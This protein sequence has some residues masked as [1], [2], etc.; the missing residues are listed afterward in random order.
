MDPVFNRTAPNILALHKFCPH[1]VF[2]PGVQ[3]SF[4]ALDKFVSS[5]LLLWWIR[6]NLS[7]LRF[8]LGSAPSEMRLTLRY[9][10]NK[11]TRFRRYTGRRNPKP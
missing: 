7:G 1:N 8:F 11:I 2:V 10:F 6:R 3:K 5:T 4:W 9:F